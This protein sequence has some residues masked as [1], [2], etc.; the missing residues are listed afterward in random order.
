MGERVVTAN[1]GDSRA[2][3]VRKEEVVGLTRDHKPFEMGEKMRIIMHGGKIYKEQEGTYKQIKLFR[4][5]CCLF[6]LF[7]LWLNPMEPI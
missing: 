4:L 5:L 3:L 1:L 7:T 2:V 6:E